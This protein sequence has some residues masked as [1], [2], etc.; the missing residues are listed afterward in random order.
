M[1]RFGFIILISLLFFATACAPASKD[2]AAETANSVD[3]TAQAPS[4]TSLEA[5]V[6]ALN[7]A[8]AAFNPANYT[9]L[10]EAVDL[11]WQMLAKIE[12]KEMFNDEADAFVPYP[13][14][15]PL[16]KALDG[17]MVQIKGYVIPT[18]EI[19]NTD[20]L[21]LSANPFSQCFF[22]GNAGPESVMDIKLAGK[23]PEFDLDQVTTFKGKL[24]LNDADLYYLNYILEEAEV[25][26]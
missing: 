26:K 16:I 13:I 20:I 11:N 7:A 24:R 5:R 22:C 17:K 10:G 9:F 23:A 18:E 21:V 6:K 15:H 4:D 14:F 2:A 1:L 25:V 19:G 3:S 8:P 12:F